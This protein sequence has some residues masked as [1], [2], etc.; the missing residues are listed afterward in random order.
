M[1]ITLKMINFFVFTF[2]ALAMAT[3]TTSY[4]TE[5]ILVS[6]NGSRV[7]VNVENQHVTAKEKEK[8]INYQI[9]RPTSRSLAHANSISLISNASTL[10]SQLFIVL[11]REYSRPDA[12]GQGYCGAGYED[13]LLL[14]E[15]FKKD[16][17]LRDRILLQ[18]CLKT[19]SM[20]IDKGDD[21][22]SN[23]L[24]HEKDGSLSYRLVEDDYKE[25]RLIKVER[26]RFKIIS[27][28]VK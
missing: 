14:V 20:F 28:P 24:T 7:T 3:S 23:G 18:S 9:D 8:N 13:Y 10:A 12:M 22:P 26:K 11:T 6:E 15:V 19:I 1:Q 21:N 17:I 16:L 4:A 2:T 5:L 25:K 27:T